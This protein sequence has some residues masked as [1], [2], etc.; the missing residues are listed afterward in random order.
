MVRNKEE[1]FQPYLISSINLESKCKK[2][3]GSGLGLAF[4][5]QIIEHHKGT[6]GSKAH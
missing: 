4:C 1:E 2:P 5:K 6:F 3:I